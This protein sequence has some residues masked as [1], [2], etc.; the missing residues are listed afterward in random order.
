MIDEAP[1]GEGVGLVAIM[2]IG[3]PGELA[4]AGDGAGLS[5][6]HQA[7]IEAVG[8]ETRHQDL[9]VGNRAAAA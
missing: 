9:R 1:Q 7:E 8:Q 3:D 6:A 2:P 4:E 5:H